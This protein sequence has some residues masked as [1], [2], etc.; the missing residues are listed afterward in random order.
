M[1]DDECDICK[2]SHNE[3]TITLLCGHKFH[4][5][6]LKVWYEFNKKKNKNYKLTCTYCLQEV[7]IDDFK[8]KTSNDKEN[9]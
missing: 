8:E 9:K 1:S 2:M 3:N 7:N 5:N 4:Y 6:C